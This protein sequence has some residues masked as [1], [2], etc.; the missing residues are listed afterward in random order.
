MSDERGPALADYADLL[1]ASRRVDWRF[2]LPDPALGHVACTSRADAALRHSCELFA[3][4]LSTL[5]G[6]G[7]DPS[8][9]S[10]DVLV[11]VDPDVAALRRAR[12]FLRPGGW[13]YVEI[14]GVLTRRG[15]RSRRPRFP[16]DYAAEL[17]RLGFDDVQA[18]WHWP[19]FDSCTQILPL[20]AR[21]VIRSA[22]LSRREGRGHSPGLMVA[23]LL[24]AS[25][26]LPFAVT[27]AS[28]IGRRPDPESQPR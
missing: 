21:D 6:K 24:V 4:S 8:P 20:G 17:G 14:H 19:D 25:Q 3:A 13:V 7:P 27:H 23:R 18:S 9:E 2:L 11:L 22:L 26:L 10:A 5:D 16:S 12:E 15:R 1:T 28:V